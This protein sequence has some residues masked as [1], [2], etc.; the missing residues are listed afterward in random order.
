[1]NSE[2]KNSAKL[3]DTAA[4]TVGAAMAILMYATIVMA[5]TDFKPTVSAVNASLLFYLISALF[6]SVMTMGMGL[7]YVI[8]LQA[9]P[10]RMTQSEETKI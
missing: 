9:L 3:I 6:P 4:R 10:E 1:M 5:M 8:S 2:K 7:A